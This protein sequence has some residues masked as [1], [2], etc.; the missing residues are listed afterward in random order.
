MTSY[1]ILFKRNSFKQFLITSKNDSAINMR[2]EGVFIF[3][4]H[5]GQCFISKPWKASKNM[6]CFD[7]SKEYRKR[8]LG[9]YELSHLVIKN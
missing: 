9:W 8:T 3:L 2:T 6:R 1:Y 7:A 5:L 4:T